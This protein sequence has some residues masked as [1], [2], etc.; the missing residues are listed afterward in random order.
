MRAG[1]VRDVIDTLDARWPGMRYR[2]CDST[3]R[4][5]PSINVFVAGR[6]AHLGTRI[7]PGVEVAII[8]AI[9]GG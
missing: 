6:R 1:S 5:R 9:V 8:T 4:I 2:L 3:P 7:D